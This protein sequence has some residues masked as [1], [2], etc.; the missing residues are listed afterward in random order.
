MNGAPL[1]GEPVDDRPARAPERRTLQGRYVWLRPVDPDADAEPLWNAAHDGSDGA[2]RVWTYLSYGPFEQDGGMREWL[3]ECE[4]SDDPLFLTVV[5]HAD[6]P[7]GMA[8][9]MNIDVAHRRLELGHIWYVPGAQR[10]EANTEATYLMLRE[11]FER[12]GHRR[13]EWKCD[14]LNERSRAAA[15]RLGFTFEA[16]FRRHMIVKGHNR[17][18]AWFSMT[19]DEWPGARAA[20]EA[21]LSADAADRPSLA[22]LRGR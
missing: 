20:F 16:V 12:L 6:G 5:S 18:S 3:R 2:S 4:P 8:A 19:D 1:L 17:D 11:A 7:V 15:L 21:W 14:A 10:T 13:V 22:S 9:F